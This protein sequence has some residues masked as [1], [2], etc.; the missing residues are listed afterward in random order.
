MLVDSYSKKIFNMSY[1]FTGTHEEAEDLTQEIFLK[2]FRSLVKYDFTRNFNAWILTLTRN[3]L[4]DQY[5]R[6]KWEKKTRDDFDEYTLAASTHTSPEHRLL[7]QENKKI[8]WEGFNHLSPDIRMTVILKDIQ[9]KAY[10]EIAEIMNLP[11]GTIKSRVNRG[12]IQLA[13][14][15]KENK[16]K[17]NEL[18]KN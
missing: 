7:K 6:T 13:K 16:E 17:E 14:I 4:I 12:R 18:R 15:L 5:R 11:L 9:G 3:H 1:Q 2:I 8:I 10:E